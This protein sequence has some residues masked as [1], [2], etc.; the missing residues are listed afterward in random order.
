[1]R[2]LK[3][4]LQL[5]RDRD[6]KS[7]LLRNLATSLILYEK[8]KTTKTKAKAVTPL[9][10]KLIGVSKET[11]R[12]EAIRKINRVVFDK[13]ASKKLIENLSKRYEN[14][15]SGYTRTLLL[16]VRKGD[17]APLVQIELV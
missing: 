12:P 7:A 10:H 14:R 16:G 1:M 2:H 13:N 6:H 3:K 17:N 15:S 11:N 9:V 8:I 4:K 5:S